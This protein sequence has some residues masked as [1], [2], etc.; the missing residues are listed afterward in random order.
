MLPPAEK[1]N[2]C[3]SLYALCMSGSGFTEWGAG[4]G[5]DLGPTVDTMKMPFDASGYKGIAFW[6]RIEAGTSPVVRVSLKD[7]DT[8]PEGGKCDESMPSGETACN[9][10]WGKTINVTSEWKPYTVMFDEMRQ[11]GWG[12]TYSAF[13]ATTVFGLQWQFGPNLDFDLCIDD[14][15]LVR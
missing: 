4:M 14:V 2:R 7:G 9:D 3:E 1:M 15:Q 8:A 12:A 5:T 10:D 11:S 13:D 6:A